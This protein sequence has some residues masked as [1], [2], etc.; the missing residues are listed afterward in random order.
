SGVDAA[1]V[2]TQSMNSLRPP[3]IGS[4]ILLYLSAAAFDTVCGVVDFVVLGAEVAGGVAEFQCSDRA[5]ATT[6]TA[7][8]VART[9]PPS[10]ANR[11]PRRRPGL[12]RGAGWSCQR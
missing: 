7:T 4:A 3:Y 10:A 11:W 8:T 6:P 9:N 1:V 12:I 2:W 5:S